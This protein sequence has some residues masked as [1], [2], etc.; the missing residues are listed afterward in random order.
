LTLAQAAIEQAGEELIVEFI[1]Q[2]R[3]SKDEVL[4]LHP[5]ACRWQ[6]QLSLTALSGPVF[7]GATRPGNAH[8]R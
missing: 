2:T 3:A 6:V 1:V 8:Q 7:Q 5:G 4:G